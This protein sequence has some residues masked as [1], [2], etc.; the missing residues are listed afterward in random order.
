MSPCDVWSCL[1]Q[2]G[3]G[4]ALGVVRSLH[5]AGRLDHVY[6]LETRP[7]NQG[8]RLTAF[9]VA[10]DKLPGMPIIPGGICPLLF[11]PTDT[12]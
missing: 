5:S 3:Y 11:S 2:G 6:F 1:L 4:T 9:E 8:G 10:H 12:S 7:Y